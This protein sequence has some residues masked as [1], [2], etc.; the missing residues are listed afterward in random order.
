M[1]RR[2]QGTEMQS[3]RS[4]CLPEIGNWYAIKL[5]AHTYQLTISHNSAMCGM[6]NCSSRAAQCS[7][8]HKTA[9]DITS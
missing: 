3:L 2:M 9:S 7:F 5:P 1:G 6:N 4:E 8:R